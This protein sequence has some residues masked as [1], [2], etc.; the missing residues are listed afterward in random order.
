M[1]NEHNPPHGGKQPIWA[2]W[3]DAKKVFPAFNKEV[4]A[5]YTI[6][7]TDSKGKKTGNVFGYYEIVVCESVIETSAGKTAS[8]RD[9]HYNGCTPL[10][11][12]ELP[13]SPMVTKQQLKK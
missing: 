12:C 10:Y 9:R 7:S 2:E 8:W 13:S 4:L 5:F 11:W 1:S 3:F 6:E